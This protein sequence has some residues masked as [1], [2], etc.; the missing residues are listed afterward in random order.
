MKIKG[1]TL[2]VINFKGIYRI[3][4]VYRGIN[5]SSKSLI[6]YFGF[7]DY[8]KLKKIHKNFLIELEVNFCSNDKYQGAFFHY[9]S[10][11]KYSIPEYSLIRDNTYFYN[12]R[13]KPN[14]N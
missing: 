3:P 9:I 6:N 7:K 10:K 2:D 12:F 11:C 8:N 13:L 14:L 1:R 5:N 4:T